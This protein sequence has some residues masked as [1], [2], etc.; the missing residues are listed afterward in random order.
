MIKGALYLFQAAL[1]CLMLG[2]PAYALDLTLWASEDKIRAEAADAPAPLWKLPLGNAMV[3]D[4]RFISADKILITLKGNSPMFPNKGVMLVD[5]RT[6][7]TI[8]KTDK[9]AFKGAYSIMA[10]TESRILYRASGPASST[11]MALD[12]RTGKVLWSRKHKKGPAEYLIDHDRGIVVAVGKQKGRRL[13]TASGLEDGSVKWERQYDVKQGNEGHPEPMLVKGALYLYHDGIEKLSTQ[14]GRT[15]WKRDDVSIKSG[16]ARIQ[17]VDDRILFISSSTALNE[18]DV[19]SGKTLRTIPLRKGGMKFTNIFP[20]GGTMYVRGEP[21][22]FFDITKPYRILAYERSTGKEMWNYDSAKPSVSNIVELN[23]R[24][25]F[26][27]AEKLICLDIST[28][29]RYFIKKVTDTGHTY[30]VR[31]KITEDSVIF[32]GEHVIAA[33]DARTGRKKYF[34]GMTPIDPLLSLTGL[35]KAIAESSMKLDKVAKKGKNAGA[36][37]SGLAEMSRLQAT[38]YQNMATKH[39]SAADRAFSEGDS[40]RWQGHS[41]LGGMNQEFAKQ[42]ALSSALQSISALGDILTNMIEILVSENMLEVQKLFRAAIFS[43]YG[44][45]EAGPYVFRPDNDYTFVGVSVIHLPSGRMR[46]TRLSPQYQEYGFWNLVDF[47]KGVVYHHGLGLDPNSYKL[48]KKFRN[49]RLV[50]VRM[51]NSYLIAR[52]IAVP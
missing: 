20:F 32:I 50:K 52:P 48:S 17:V 2:P 10:A 5:A 16:S 40:L 4:M 6:G 37:E 29:G 36:V 21:R 12:A 45:A 14:T 38:M 7:R 9:K 42:A 31:L 35:D 18:V 43:L 25:Y 34:Y 41:A 47:E 39:F 23:G 8:W 26:A 49:F 22:V 30:P 15:A 27:T 3:K 13:I 24:V 1:V 51:Y 44:Q 19:D 46:Y 33:Y 11:L 28:G